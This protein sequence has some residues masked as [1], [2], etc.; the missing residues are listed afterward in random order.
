[1]CAVAKEASS[2]EAASRESCD[3][4]MLKLRQNIPSSR[5]PVLLITP[6]YISCFLYWT[7]GANPT[8]LAVLPSTNLFNF[9]LDW[10]S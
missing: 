4:G 5:F 2:R 10:I 1:M 9:V 6:E 8:K 3:H 7:P